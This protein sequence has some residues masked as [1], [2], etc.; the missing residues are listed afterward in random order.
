MEGERVHWLLAESEK[1]SRRGLLGLEGCI[2]LRAKRV[3]KVCDSSKCCSNSRKRPVK[4]I[5]FDFEGEKKREGSNSSL[6]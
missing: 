4:P 2:V 6:G 1:G 3:Y 5:N